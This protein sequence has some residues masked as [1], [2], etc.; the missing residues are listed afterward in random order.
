MS[1]GSRLPTSPL[2]GPFLQAALLCEKVL[3]EPDGVPSAIRI[4]DQLTIQRVQAEGEPAGPEPPAVMQLSL[5]VILKS[6]DA[7]GAYVIRVRGRAPSGR[8]TDF[9]V[10]RSSSVR[11]TRAA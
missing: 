1:A 11:P 4:V 2:D 9:P 10:A 3:I 8:A 6:G 7:P 5:L